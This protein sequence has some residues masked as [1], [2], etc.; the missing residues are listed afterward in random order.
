MHIRDYRQ[1]ALLAPPST[2]TPPTDPLPRLSGVRIALDTEERDD[3]L[4]RDMGPGWHRSAGWLCGVSVAWRDGADVRRMY[5]PVRHPETE[6]RPQGEV[7]EWVEHLLRECEV[8][9][10][11]MGFDMGWLWASGC[12]VWPQRAHETQFMSVMLDENWR[13][14]SL[15]EC[16]RRADVPGKNEQ[17][18]REAAAAL[19]CDP[20][21]DLWR[22][23][24]RYVGPY[25]EDDAAATLLLA[26]TLLPQ[27]EADGLMRAYQTEID[28]VPCLHAMRIRGLRVDLDQADRVRTEM[29]QRRQAALDE[30]GRMVG[31]RVSMLDMNSSAAVGRVL[32]KCDAPLQYTAKGTVSVTKEYLQKLDHPVGRLIRQARQYDG[33]AEK[34]VGTYLMEFEHMGRVHPDI[35]QLRDT[36]GGTRSM[37]LSYSNPPMQQSPARDDELG[38]MFRRIMLPEDGELWGAADFASQEPRFTVHY[39]GVCR[40]RGAQEMV[41]Y[42]VQDV[43]PTTESGR[44]DLHSWNAR[45]LKWKRKPAK[46]LYQAMAYGAQAAKIALMRGC[47]L[48]EAKEV[49]RT[50]N[51][52]LPW[53]SGLTEYCSEMAM[54]RGW[55]RLIDGAR[56]HFDH[57][58]PRGDRTS[59]PMRID[60]AREMWPGRQLERAHGHK[61]MNR[62]AQGSSARQTKMAMVEAH[63]AGLP[64]I[65]QMHDEIGISSGSERD[66]LLLSEI[67]RD[68]VKLIVPVRVDLE[69][70]RTW[71]D[72]KHTFEEARA[73]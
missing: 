29:R 12:R 1:T 22:M 46:D 14:Y 21:V 43:D 53:I 23:P 69:W 18:L 41:D 45:L 47:S 9:F 68:V 67:M 25:A 36:D 30:I 32:Q 63:R 27:M 5:V 19:G 35:H 26:E 11:N 72:A 28:L 10:H 38:P 40:M 70:G 54:T 73:A 71:G 66:G 55:V 37:R 65:I 16:A 51:S 7:I 3:G 61:A 64:L 15:D 60:Q 48:D 31:W 17:L 44:A 39:A 13:D 33:M 59:A 58:V 8:C 56:C 57:W 50:F 6:C 34:F 20:K 49:V 42:F 4:A 62:V 2:W 24:A 52:T